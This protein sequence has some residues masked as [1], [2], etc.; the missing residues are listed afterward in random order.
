MASTSLTPQVFRAPDPEVR[1][2]RVKLV[3][4]GLNAT[5]L[6]LVIG[7]TVAPLLDPSRS[8]APLRLVIGTIFG[9]GFIL[10]ALW[11]LRYMKRSES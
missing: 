4:T 7:S 5:G 11:L 8:V 10:A 3:S 1:K 6:A 2:E 9:L